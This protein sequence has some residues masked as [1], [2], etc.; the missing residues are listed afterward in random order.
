[1][2]VFRN[3][4]THLMIGKRMLAPLANWNDVTLFPTQLMVVSMWF[5]FP[6]SL[7][8]K[9]KEMIF[10][11]ISMGFLAQETPAIPTNPLG[12]NWMA[13]NCEW[14]F[15]N[16]NMKEWLLVPTLDRVFKMNMSVMSTRGISE[17]Y[18][19]PET[20]FQW[21]CA[22]QW[23]YHHLAPL[24]TEDH[25]RWPGQVC[26]V[27][28][29]HPEFKWVN[30]QERWPVIVS[31]VPD[32]CD[33]NHHEKTCKHRI[34]TWIWNSYESKGFKM[35]IWD[36]HKIPNACCHFIS[37]TVTSRYRISDWGLASFPNEISTSAIEFGHTNVTIWD[38]DTGH[39]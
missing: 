17:R 3:Q 16:V 14:P 2:L 25:G 20:V 22:V 7:V 1:M 6:F 36:F 9:S 34:H 35:S 18:L 11:Q 32:G 31:D 30:A 5:P 23:I 27:L 29:E 28:L 33:G 39:H 12:E 13:V 21:T 15:L 8:L 19:F 37:S 38:T 4:T 24:L 10:A 26:Y